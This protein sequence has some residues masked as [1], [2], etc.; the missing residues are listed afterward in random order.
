MS[1]SR[2]VEAVGRDDARY[3]AALAGCGGAP[4]VLYVAGGVE[5]LNELL[6]QGAV[7]IVGTRQATDYGMETARALARDLTASGV[8]VL[9]A[10]AEGIAAAA[11]MGALERGGGRTVTVMPAGLDVCRPASR[12]ALYER[13]RT[14]GSA[15]S[16]LPCGAQEHRFGHAAR[17]RIVA[18]MAGLV[19][20]VEA[21]DRPGALREARAAQQ[22][23]R[24]V[25]AV[26]GR[27]C[28]PVSR[29]P[30]ALLA[31]GARLVR[32]A[33][34]ALDALCGVGAVTVPANEAQASETLLDPQL[35]AVLEEVRAGRDTLGALTAAGADVR[36]TAVA[37]AELELAGA[38][39]RGDGGRYLPRG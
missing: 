10:M 7:A 6:G 21:E 28:S 37:L 23:G 35:R 38:L 32:D 3:P 11:H 12:R 22:F 16:E 36:D 14:E 8:T 25:A 39:V 1:A 18:G 24:P 19:I 26:P 20:V 15:V 5:R 29:G 17:S 2:T 30:H 34:D 9:G 33:Q 13:V 4:R 27:V 31:E